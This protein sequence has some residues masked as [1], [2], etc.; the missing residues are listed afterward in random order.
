MEHFGFGS[1]DRS[2]LG[3]SKTKVEQMEES[4]IKPIYQT[5]TW[6]LEQS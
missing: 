3:D 1:L 5:S 2:P 6:T 4:L